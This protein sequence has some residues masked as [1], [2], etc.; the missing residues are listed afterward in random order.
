MIALF[1]DH[2]FPGF[3][4]VAQ[5]VF[6]VLRDSEVVVEEE[7]RIWSAITRPRW[8]GGGGHAILLAVDAT[9]PTGSCRPTP[10][11]FDGEVRCRARR[12]VCLRRLL[13]L[14]DTRQLIVDERPELV[15]TSIPRGSAIRN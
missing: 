14:D 13:G 3:A 4:V 2:L 10:P 15:F 11:L 8:R 6:W 12:C 9:M 7:S 5:G 1:L